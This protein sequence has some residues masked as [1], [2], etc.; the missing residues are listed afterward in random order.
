ML[1][2]LLPHLQRGSCF[3]MVGVI[4]IIQLVHYPAFLWVDRKR[5]REFSRFHADSI[6]PVVLPLMVTEAGSAC[7]LLWNAWKRLDGSTDAAGLLNLQLLNVASVAVVWLWTFVVSV[8]CHERLASEG[9]DE[10]TIRWL[11]R[12]NWVRTFVWTGRGLLLFT[13]SIET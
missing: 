11:I 8:P 3:A 1:D 6:T 13:S 7:G 10:S 5:F 12:S 2:A 4:W 9:W